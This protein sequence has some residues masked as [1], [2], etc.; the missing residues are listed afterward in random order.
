MPAVRSASD[1]SNEK[2]MRCGRTETIKMAR[3]GTVFGL[4]QIGI[5]GFYFD[6]KTKY[7]TGLLNIEINFQIF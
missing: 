4:G 7:L 1:G 6:R 3:V 5:F 2:A